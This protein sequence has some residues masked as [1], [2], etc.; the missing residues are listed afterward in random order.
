[1]NK[2]TGKNIGI[3]TVAAFSIQLIFRLMGDSNK[4]AIIRG[5]ILVVLCIILAV[6]M[7]N[8]TKKK[9][10]NKLSI[11]GAILMVAAGS[12]LSFDY[13]MRKFYYQLYKEYESM[14]NHLIVCSFVALMIFLLIAL[15]K[16]D[17]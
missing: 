10:G 14:S 5:T 7:Y 17:K 16:M 6:Y 13:I 15:Y 2:N 4:S 12:A 1:M 3:I 9:L 11:V 8:G